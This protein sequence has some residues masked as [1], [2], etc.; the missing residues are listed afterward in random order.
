MMVEPV[1]NS[2]DRRTDKSNFGIV[3][4]RHINLEKML[5]HHEPP[6]MTL[7]TLI[8]KKTEKTSPRTKQMWE[9]M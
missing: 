8:K 2:L 7:K 1:K 5:E 4:K 9:K 3:P 6:E